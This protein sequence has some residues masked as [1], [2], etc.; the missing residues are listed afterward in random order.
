MDDEDL[1]ASLLNDLKAL[2]DTKTRV[3]WSKL[4]FLMGGTGGD[5]LP[6]LGSK[7]FCPFDRFPKDE[8]FNVVLVCMASWPH[9][10]SEGL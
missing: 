10:D 4:D 3:F 8:Y 1:A 7:I 5:M 2:G 6:D 9:L